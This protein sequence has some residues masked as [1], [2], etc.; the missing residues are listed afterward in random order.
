MPFEFEKHTS[1]G[2]L[3]KKFKEKYNSMKEPTFWP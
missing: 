2:V 1:K 3:Q